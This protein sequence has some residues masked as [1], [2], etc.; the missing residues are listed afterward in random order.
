VP[1]DVTTFTLSRLALIGLVTGSLD[2][3]AA[4][5]DGTVTVEG[6]PADL[7]R[8]IALLAPVD[9]DFNIVAP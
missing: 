6:D 9:P 2:F 4:T 1:A 7:G 5:A 3:G 8:L